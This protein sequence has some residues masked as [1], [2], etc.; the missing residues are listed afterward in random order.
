M[1]CGYRFDSCTIVLDSK[2]ENLQRQAK[3]V[4]LRV[5]KEFGHL[6]KLRAK[7][8]Q[9]PYPKGFLVGIDVERTPSSCKVD[10]EGQSKK[11]KREYDILRNNIKIFFDEESR[12]FAVV[13]AQWLASCKLQPVITFGD[14]IVLTMDDQHVY[15]E[16]V[17]SVVK[18]SSSAVPESAPISHVVYV[19]MY[20]QFQLRDALLEFFSANPDY[21]DVCALGDDNSVFCTVGSTTMRV[22]CYVKR[23]PNSNE[24]INRAHIERLRCIIDTVCTVF[25]LKSIAEQ[26]CRTW[27]FNSRDP[28]DNCMYVLEYT[29]SRVVVHDTVQSKPQHRQ[30]N[31]FGVDTTD[32]DLL[33]E[34]GDLVAAQID[35]YQ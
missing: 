33:L 19:H 23:N 27:E 31:L 9:I 2:Y 32:L 13:L 4:V 17:D 25:S 18:T 29:P 8:G 3:L 28:I 26:Y 6:D 1:N 5:F 20:R 7:L 10:C 12:Q 21:R 16:T 34:S 24:I 30:H 15:Y 22:A 35:N 11:K 14:R